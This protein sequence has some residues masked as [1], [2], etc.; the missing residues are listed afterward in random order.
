MSKMPDKI[1]AG[2]SLYLSLLLPTFV[3]EGW[4][5]SFIF[6]SA[7]EK[8]ATVET[9]TEG[10][11]YVLSVPAAT[12]ADWTGTVFYF[13]RLS[14]G[15]EVQTVYTGQI[16]VK[17]NPAVA[18]F[19]NRTHVKKVLDAIEAVIENRAS[20]DQMSYSI[21]G[22]SL[23]RLGIEQLLYFRDEYRR[24]YAIEQKKSGHSLGKSS[25]IKVRF[26]S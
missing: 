11:N 25:L 5:L 21:A 17:P 18:G 9:T 26:W 6:S 12:T 8:L 24:M 3:A 14:L 22:R 1:Y 7:T 23:S 10:S 4:S 2:D 20:T 16:E 15:S 13:G 19:D